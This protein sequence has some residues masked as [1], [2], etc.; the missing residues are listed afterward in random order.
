M[1]I[2]DEFTQYLKDNEF[3]ENHID[4]A[5]MVIK[6]FHNYLKSVERDITNPNHED[7]YNFATR[8]IDVDLN[9][10]DNFITLLYFGRFMQSDDI[11]VAAMETLDGWEMFPNLSSQILEQ[12]GQECHDTIFKG[13]QLPPPGTHPKLKPNYTRLFITRIVNELGRDKSVD[14]FKQGLRDPYPSSYVR[15]REKYLETKD[16]NEVLKF[17]HQQ[18]VDVL[19]KHLEEGSLFFTQRVTPQVIEFVEQDQSISAGI[20]EGNTIRMKKIP[21]MTEDALNA[22]DPHEQAYFTCHNPMFRE[23]LLYDKKPVDPSFC[24]CSGGF[25]K[26]YWEAVLERE[27]DVELMDSPLLGGRFCEFTI[28]LNDDI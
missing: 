16:I 2:I 1:D 11:I 21:Y 8:L 15:G 12:F 20:R 25:M 9:T 28:H 4:N 24:N 7:F 14:F 27:V 3:T 17:K 5:I 26:N 22:T 10:Y 23:A 18:L 13:S 6:Q 19:K